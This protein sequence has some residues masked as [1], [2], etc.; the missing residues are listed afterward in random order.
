M[1]QIQNFQYNPRLRLGFE[2]E[3]SITRMQKKSSVIGNNMKPKIT[4]KIAR[5]IIGRK[6]SEENI[7]ATSKC[8]GL[9]LPLL[10][11]PKMSY[12]KLENRL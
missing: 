11:S 6:I 3:N 4:E 10:Y 12:F 1:I 9:V 2:F 5:S 7:T 8:S